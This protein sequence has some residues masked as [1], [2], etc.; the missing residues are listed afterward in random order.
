MLNEWSALVFTFFRVSTWKPPRWRWR[1]RRRR[2]SK[3]CMK[4][5]CN[6]VLAVAVAC[7]EL[8]TIG[9]RLCYLPF[10]LMSVCLHWNSF[11][12]K[13]GFVVCKC[14]LQWCATI[15]SIGFNWPRARM[16]KWNT[17]NQVW[18]WQ[19][20][21]R[22]W[23]II[24]VDVADIFHIP[25]LNILHFRENILH[26]S[27]CFSSASSQLVLLC[28]AKKSDAYAIVQDSH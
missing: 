9:F 21:L 6:V 15:S 18:H 1:C 19:T 25:H 27:F 17:E 14:V 12:A 28:S 7:I 11:H 24:I 10:I 3:K 8:S 26:S 22:L 13:Y 4:L 5:E 23:Q 2:R 20:S 16:P